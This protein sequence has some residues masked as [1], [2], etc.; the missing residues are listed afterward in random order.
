MLFQFQT[1]NLFETKVIAPNLCLYQAILSPY[2]KFFGFAEGSFSTFLS[3]ERKKND[4]NYVNTD[5]K[6]MS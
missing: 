4:C 2:K 3:L 5:F 1:R 6:V